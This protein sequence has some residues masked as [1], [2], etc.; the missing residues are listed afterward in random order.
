MKRVVV[1]GLGCI[2]PIGNSVEEFRE[3]LYAGRTG[4]APFDTTFPGALSPDPGLRFRTTA[5]VKGFDPVNNPAQ[6]LA[7]GVIVSSDSSAQFGIIAAR[8][9]AAH[10][11]PS[12]PLRS[13]EHCHHHRMRL[14]RARGR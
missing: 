4:I 13:V 3:S 8:Q 9:A 5:K 12:P 7:S 1:T 11:A 10:S 14:R 6:R 2:T